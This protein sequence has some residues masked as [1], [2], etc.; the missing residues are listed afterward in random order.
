MLD[1]LDPGAVLVEHKAWIEKVAR[2]TCR[3]HSVLDEDAADFAGIAFVKLVEDDYAALRRF[4]GECDIKTYL[5]TLV[6][7]GFQEYAR[8]RWGR[9]RTSAPARRLGPAAV[10]LEALVYRDGYRLDEAVEVLTTSG[11]VRETRRELAQLFAQIPVR[12]PRPRRDD[13]PGRL[14]DEPDAAEAD[15]RMLG[16]ETLE[17]CREVMDALFRSLSELEPEEQVLVRGRFMESRTVADLARA[18][19]VPQMPLYRRIEKL[20]GRLRGVL[21]EAGVRREDVAECIEQDDP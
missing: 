6:V 13:R 21:E 14:D 20:L 5:A 1:R 18:L 10:H 4:R 15:Q 7:R 9:W 3:K 8:A 12:R 16:D 11:R 19:G 17:R 2:I